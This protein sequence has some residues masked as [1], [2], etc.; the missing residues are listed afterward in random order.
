MRRLVLVAVVLAVAVASAGLLFQIAPSGDRT[1]T[2]V[3]LDEDG[4]ARLSIVT[5]VD[6]PNESDRAAFEE[7]Q[8]AIEAPNSSYRTRFR[9]AVESLVDRANRSTDR[10]MAATD[11]AVTTRIEPLP[12]RR[13]IVEY[14]FTWTGFA[15]SDGD[16]LRVADAISGYVLG[17]SEALEITVPEGYA[18][19]AVAPEPDVR[20]ND[21]VR[22]EGPLTFA[23]DR[24]RLAAVPGTGAGA[25][26]GDAG[27]G[28][29]LLPWLALGV[30]AVLAVGGLVLYR[31]RSADDVAPE[32]TD[33]ERVVAMMEDA[34]GQMK[35][36]RLTE[37]TSWSPAK[38]SQV[39]S[40]L[41]EAGEIEKLR[42]GREN[43]LRFPDEESP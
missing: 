10:R 35:Q 42:M 43:I 34:G 3:Q 37:E 19:D 13:G 36:K 18:V 23:E 12:V 25:G 28:A 22:W 8:T 32:M 17:E 16:R 41:E 6:L 39:T 11:V 30:V 38:V 24:P 27:E 7:L 4:A 29:S 9:D 20:R 33:G 40:D 21:S 15:T 14:S 5:S 31:R 1:V 26:G 2:R